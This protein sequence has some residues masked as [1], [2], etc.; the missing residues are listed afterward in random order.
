ML[1]WIKKR[2]ELVF[3]QRLKRTFPFLVLS[4]AGMGFF[5]LEASEILAPYFGAG[6]LKTVISLSLL[7]SGGLGVYLLLLKITRA[8]TYKEFSDAMR[9]AQKYS[10]VVKS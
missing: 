2:R 9:R 3:D 7:I 10:E 4:A 8:F 6:I 5:L 1:Y